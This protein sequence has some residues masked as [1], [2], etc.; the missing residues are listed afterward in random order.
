MLVDSDFVNAK[1]KGEGLETVAE[2]KKMP[3]QARRWIVSLRSC[4]QQDAEEISGKYW[5]GKSHSKFV[6]QSH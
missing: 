6:L 5:V 1:G 4:G 2:S 3:A